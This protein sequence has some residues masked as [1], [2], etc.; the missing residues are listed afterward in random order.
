MELYLLRHGETDWNK[1]KLLQGHTDTLLNDKGRMQVEETARKLADLNL[2][3]D[4]IVTSPL[5]RARESAAIAARVLGYPP[6]RIAVEPLL[7]E[8][9]F[10]EGEGMALAEM[11]EKYPDRDCPG[12]ESKEELIARAG[13][14]LQTITE[15]FRD[16]ERILLTAHGAVLF[17]L[18]EAASEEP[19]PYQGRSA[20]IKQGCLYRISWEG[21]RNTFAGY[22]EETKTFVE[23]DAAGLGREARIYL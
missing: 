2:R 11:K 8:R 14:A 13:L 9:G 6:E 23:L 21:G 7:I 17:A 16:A 20:C 5:K 4:A 18:L 22:D 1:E 19:I 10:G 12:M 15:T 3:M